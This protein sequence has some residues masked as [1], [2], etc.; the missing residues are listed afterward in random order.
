MANGSGYRLPSMFSNSVVYTE[1]RALTAPQN[2]S[3]YNV[4]G[5]ITASWS[6]VDNAENYLVEIKKDGAVLSSFPV[7]CSQQIFANVKICCV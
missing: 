1:R 4:D 7:M 5:K 6:E 2:L 3:F